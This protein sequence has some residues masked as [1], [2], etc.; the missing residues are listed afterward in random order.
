M[1][2]TGLAILWN[3]C[4]KRCSVDDADA[5]RKSGEVRTA[6]NGQWSRCEF[7]RYGQQPDK[8]RCK[9]LL[10]PD[11]SLLVCDLCPYMQMNTP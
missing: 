9:A 6:R 5:V 8:P 10:E 3:A 2:M 7:L 4:S 11:V 1:P